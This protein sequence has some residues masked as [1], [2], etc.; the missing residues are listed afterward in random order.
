MGRYI[1]FSTFNHN[2]Q[3]QILTPPIA[4][5]QFLVSFAWLEESLAQGKLLPPNAYRVF[6]SSRSASTGRS[7]AR[8]RSASPDTAQSRGGNLLESPKGSAHPLAPKTPATS[9]Q[10]R[11]REAHER[12]EDLAA[13]VQ[14]DN[15]QSGA[16]A[17]VEGEEGGGKPE[18]REGEGGQGFGLQGDWRPGPGDEQL[19]KWGKVR[20]DVTKEKEAMGIRPLGPTAEAI[21]REVMRIE[22]PRGVEQPTLSGGGS[23][24]DREIL[25]RAAKRAR[26]EG[27]DSRGPQGGLERA[28]VEVNEE[29]FLDLRENQTPAGM[30]N[31]EVNRGLLKVLG[32]LKDIYRDGKWRKDEKKILEGFL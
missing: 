18:R 2:W 28:L 12:A 13:E 17:L 32:E 30:A 16:V 27:A 31:P 6:S 1:S 3:S 24:E 11:L 20:N 9:A 29:G 14:R 7:P 25:Q 21:G 23:D 10:K 4:F 26:I 22:P 15:E 5:P 8:S 19:E